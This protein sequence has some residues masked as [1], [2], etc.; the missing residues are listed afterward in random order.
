MTP[1]I[2]FV[3]P[4]KNR[5][6]LIGETIESLRNQT[7]SDW[8][9]IIVDDH[10]DEHDQTGSIVQKINDARIRY[11]RLPD[12]HGRNSPSARNFGNMLATAPIIAVCDSDD[13][14]YPN[15][16]AITLNAFRDQNCD[17]FYANY[18]KWD[19]VSN[20]MLERID[21][22]VVD[23]DPEVLKKY[24][25]I[26][27]GSSAYK[28]AL[29]TEF[30]Y[31]SFFRRSADYDLFCRLSAAGKKFFYS[32]E[33]VFKHR[34]H[35]SNLSGGIAHPPYDQLIWQN[36]GWADFNPKLASGIVETE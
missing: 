18:D 24:D 8:E 14:Y 15:R 29:A 35:G 6:D 17:V 26:P 32:P 33:K 19:E 11:Y 13:I 1:R 5:A 20:S 16:A 30:P 23:Y 27:H 21:N 25:P 9:L 36:R 10:S 34:I 28:R 22:P 12:D 2:S 31:N 3:M 4:T 7:I